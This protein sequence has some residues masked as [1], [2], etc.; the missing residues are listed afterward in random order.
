MY[1]FVLLHCSLKWQFAAELR[2][3]QQSGLMRL[4][5]AGIAVPAGDSDCAISTA[6]YFT[7]T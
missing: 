3:K 1:A 2:A 7:D 5:K 4:S 6:S